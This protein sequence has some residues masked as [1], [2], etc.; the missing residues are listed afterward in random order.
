MQSFFHPKD[1][2]IK[3]KF[4]LAFTSLLVLTR[5]ASIQVI[6]CIVPKIFAIHL[7]HNSGDDGLLLLCLYDAG[8]MMMM[9]HVTQS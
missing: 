8:G 2:N 4:P 9:M 3:C 5:T 1:I 7:I 6:S